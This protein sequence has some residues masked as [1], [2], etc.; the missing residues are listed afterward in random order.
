MYLLLYSHKFQIYLNYFEFDWLKISTS[1]AIE[2][3]VQLT[4][5][6]SGD[7]NNNYYFIVVEVFFISLKY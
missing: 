3:G 7:N 6:C 5:L 2:C 1:L 4:E